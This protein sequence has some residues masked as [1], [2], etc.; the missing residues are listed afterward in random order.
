MSPA[1]SGD[2][3]ANSRIAALCSVSVS[4]SGMWISTVDREHRRLSLS[5][6]ADR[7]TVAYGD[8]RVQLFSRPL[9]DVGLGLMTARLAPHDQRT[10]AAAPGLAS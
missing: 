10:L 3:R 6:W 2:Y 4:S 5:R 7:G 8:D 9:A 1:R